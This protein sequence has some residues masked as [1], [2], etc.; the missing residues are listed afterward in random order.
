MGSMNFENLIFAEGKGYSRTGAY[1]RSKLANLLFTYELQRRFNAAGANAL[2]VAAHPGTSRTN[3]TSHLEE[4]WYGRLLGP[5]VLGMLQSAAMGALPTI[6]AAVDPAVKGG[7]YYGPG[8]FMEQRGYPVRVES[9]AA[10]HNEA[11][12]RRLWQISEELTGIEFK[13]LKSANGRSQPA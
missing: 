13:Q 2:S 10:S 6:R 1:G 5:L 4:Q 11:N 7:E 8:G 9:S 3:L 12:A